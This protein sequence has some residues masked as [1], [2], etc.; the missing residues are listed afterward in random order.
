MRVDDLRCGKS[1]NRM[2]ASALVKW[3]DCDRPERL[4]C[5]DTDLRFAEDLSPNPNAFLL[6]TA[7]FALRHGEKRV[8]GDGQ[9]C[10]TLRNGVV[11]AMQQIRLWHG[12]AL[13]GPVTIEATGGFAPPVPRPA[14]RTAS[15]MSG[16]VE[17]FCPAE[18]S[19]GLSSR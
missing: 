19:A 2:S 10:P 6:A 18:E 14:R 7:M 1:G 15:L 3:A 12:P 9:L 4:V 11:T 17:A 8:L 16:G 13:G 5:F